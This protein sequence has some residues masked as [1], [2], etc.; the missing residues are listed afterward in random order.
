MNYLVL[1]NGCFQKFKRIRILLVQHNFVDE[2]F[3]IITREIQAF[4][5]LQMTDVYATSLIYILEDV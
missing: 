4:V 3:A 2:I 1:L 5:Q